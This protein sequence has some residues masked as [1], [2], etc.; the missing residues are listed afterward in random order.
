MARALW[1]PDP[2]RMERLLRRLRPVLESLEPVLRYAARRAELRPSGLSDPSFASV[3][4]GAWA[5]LGA[6]VSGGLE[7]YDLEV[8][9]GEVRGLRG[10]EAAVF[11]PGHQD[12]AVFVVEVVGA[13]RAA[14]ARAAARSAAQDPC[15]CSGAIELPPGAWEHAWWIPPDELHGLWTPA[16]AGNEEAI[17]VTRLIL[18]ETAARSALTALRSVGLADGPAARYSTP[19]GAPPA[20]AT[21]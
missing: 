5:Q 21:R 3:P 19:A 9:A 15:A 17:P 2:D 11:S 8:L 10:V 16:L 13:L 18:H 1:R 20:E 14:N 4:G 7:P 12:P 6:I